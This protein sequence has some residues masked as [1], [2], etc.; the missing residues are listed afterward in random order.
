M[1][2]HI[3]QMYNR[4]EAHRNDVEAIKMQAYMKGQFPFV[5]IKTQERRALTQQH[6]KSL[7]L[8][9]VDFLPFA[10]L[11]LKYPEREMHHYALDT[12]A[13]FKK[14]HSTQ[15]LEVST[16]F[17]EK[18]AWWDTVDTANSVINKNIFLKNK[19]LLNSKSIE[20]MQDANFW[21]RR[22]AIIAQLKFK[23]ETDTELLSAVIRANLGTQEFFINKAI[24]WALR[25]YGDHNPDWVI[26]FAKHTDLHPLSRREALRKII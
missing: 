25:D 4:F 12:I 11:C 26:N 10:Q 3:G 20:W 23:L 22:L 5:G 21:K 16:F 9:V 13:S 7:S 8:E 19:D 1:K 14:K 18:Y 2:L 24:G 15:T 6:N 17:C